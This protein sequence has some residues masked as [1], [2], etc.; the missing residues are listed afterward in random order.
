MLR[1]PVI[2]IEQT[3]MFK[4]LQECYQQALTDQ[5][6]V[7]MHRVEALMEAVQ[8]KGAWT[9]DLQRAASQVIALHSS[10]HLKV[11]QGS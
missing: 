6:P 4:R 5:D 9:S 2:P 3:P 8:A 11:V 7:R 10:E 1:G